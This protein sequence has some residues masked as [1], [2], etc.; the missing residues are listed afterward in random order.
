MGYTYHLLTC[1]RL[2][3]CSRRGCVDLLLIY[4][5]I[6]VAY[7]PSYAQGA[8]SLAWALPVGTYLLT[9]NLPTDPLT[10]LPSYA[11]G[12]WSL[13]WAMPEPGRLR[14]LGLSNCEVSADGADL[15]LTLTLT[16]SLTLTPA[17]TLTR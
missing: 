16:L 10:H 17:L 5:L 15:T 13:A 4:P 6:T 12:A 1:Y 2:L 8:W 3:T 7:L 9:C 14:S 11:K